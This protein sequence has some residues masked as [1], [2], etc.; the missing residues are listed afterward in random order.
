MYV[1]Y[2]GEKKVG[3]IIDEFYISVYIANF[4]LK[5]E[6]PEG[7]PKKEAILIYRHKVVFSDG[8]VLPNIVQLLYIS[9]VDYILERLEKHGVYTTDILWLK[10]N[11]NNYIGKTYKLS[12]FW[13]NYDYS[14]SYSY[15]FYDVKL[16]K[17]LGIIVTKNPIVD[18]NVCQ[19]VMLEV[20][21][22]GKGHGKTIV[23]FLKSIKDISGF[24]LY[25]T[26]PFWKSCGAEVEENG[27]FYIRR[28]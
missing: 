27:K 7:L 16:K 12:S 1:V 20:F 23:D 10:T 5:T 28:S 2:Q 9:N 13:E 14:N 25:S 11:V 22:K 4:I 21:E 26:V 17:S 24:S 8:E 3:Y 18:Q 6:M 19:I 15:E